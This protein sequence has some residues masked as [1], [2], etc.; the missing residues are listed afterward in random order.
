M[1]E[2]PQ[3][4][5]DNREY[6]T[7]DEPLRIEEGNRDGGLNI[8]EGDLAVLMKCVT[9]EDKAYFI[10]AGRSANILRSET[11]VAD[12][13]EIR[14]YKLKGIGN[15]DAEK[16]TVSP[17]VDEAF[18]NRDI[19]EAD[20]LIGDNRIKLMRLLPPFTVHLGIN[21]DGSLRA[22]PDIAKPI[23]GMAAGRGEN[24]F[25]I[26]I[27]LHKN[28]VPACGPIAWGKYLDLTWQGKPME[29]VIL[30]QPDAQLCRLGNYLQPDRKTN[31]AKPNTLI[32]KIIEQKFGKNPDK[33]IELLALELSS[34]MGFS[35]GSVVRQAHEDAGVCRFGCHTG[36]FSYLP[37]K[38]SAYMHDFDSS[39]LISSLAPEAR[40]LSIARDLA[41]ALIGYVDIIGESELYHSINNPEEFERI[42]PVG[43]IVRGYYSNDI[44][45]DI[46]EK[47][48]EIIG[49]LTTSISSYFPPNPT[50][51]ERREWSHWLHDQVF[52]KLVIMSYS[53]FCQSTLANE[54]KPPY[55]LHELQ[56]NLIKFRKDSD[57]AAKNNILKV[58]E[59]L[60]EWAK[61]LLDEELSRDNS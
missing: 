23:G 31:V 16:E 51:H 2:K 61:K 14:G 25:K 8:P 6:L 12:G 41:S 46:T 39:V 20:A 34:Q 58:R 49:E 53:L 27:E 42:N 50:I 45:Q 30:S 44:N 57:L 19:S 29:Y 35:I 11:I 43:Q 24:E 60:P 56:K 13:T 40:A 22:I 33:P 38:N 18:V 52:H 10:S 15:Y 48:I 47:V 36:N 1:S 5:R 21:D 26:A 54:Y 28:G 3:E 4:L 9:W 59:E 37:D 7:P 55:S 17:P 32:R